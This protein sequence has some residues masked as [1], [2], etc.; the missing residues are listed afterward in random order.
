VRLQVGQA[1]S[2]SGW[3]GFVVS[4]S[5]AATFC[6]RLCWF[7]ATLVQTGDSENVRDSK[8]SP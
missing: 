6:P 7:V 1:A 5:A 2:F 3:P 8:G 4:V